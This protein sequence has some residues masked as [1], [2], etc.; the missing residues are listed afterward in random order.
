MREFF[1]NLLKHRTDF[2][3]SLLP[4][5][6]FELFVT[7]YGTLFGRMDKAFFIDVDT[8]VPGDM[9]VVQKED[10]VAFLRV[11]RE[12]EGGAHVNHAVRHCKAVLVIEIEYQTAAIKALR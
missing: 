6:V 4:V 3:E 9:V 12:F 8:H 2:H 10:H 5:R 11:F 1:R 7:D